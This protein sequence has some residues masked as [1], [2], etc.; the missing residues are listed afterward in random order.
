MEIRLRKKNPDG[1]MRVKSSGE[2]KEVII[3]EDMLHP[4]EESISVC[5]KGKGSSGIIDFKPDEIEKLYNTVKKR[6]HLIKGLKSL[7]GY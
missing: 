4:N 6:M 7:R 1:I 3:N 5:F 2:V